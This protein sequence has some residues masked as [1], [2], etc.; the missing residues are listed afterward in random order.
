MVKIPNHQKTARKACGTKTAEMAKRTKRPELDTNAPVPTMRCFPNQ[1]MYVHRRCR[2][3]ATCCSNWPTRPRG[4]LASSRSRCC[5][6]G[7]CLCSAARPVKARKAI[8]N[9]CNGGRCKK[10]CS[11]C[12]D[13]VASAVQAAWWKLGLASRA[14]SK[15]KS[16]RSHF[17]SGTCA[18]VDHKRAGTRK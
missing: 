11:K 18:R 9:R 14:H 17:G 16:S 4:E 6:G 15:K 3:R 1:Y 8:P 5:S 13:R 2:P 7:F 12:R 10:T